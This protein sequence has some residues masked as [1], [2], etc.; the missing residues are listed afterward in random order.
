[1]S[2]RSLQY[3]I[4]RWLGHPDTRVVVLT[5]AALVGLAV[6]T[7]GLLVGILGP[8]LAIAFTG[9]LV[10]GLAILRDVRAGI[11]ATIAVC[12]LLPFATFPVD[13]G[14][15]PTFLNAVVG[16]VFLVYVLRL[17]TRRDSTF[18]TTSV[19]VPLAVFLL[20][21]LVAFAMGLTHS[22]PT[23]TVLRKFLEVLLALSMFY[24]MV[25]VVR[26]PQELSL[27]TRALILTGTGAAV[28]AILLY[29]MPIPWTVRVL[30]ALARLGYP[31][32]FGALRWIE[33]DP[34]NPMRAIGTAIDPNVLGGMMILAG[35]LTGPQLAS[36]RPLF[37][38]RWVFL[39]YVAQ[40]VALYLT[41][42]RGS[43]IGLFAALVVLAVLK[44]RRLLAF[45]GLGG[46]ILL[47]LPWSQAYVQHFIAGLQGQDR[48]TQ[49]RFGEY[50]DALRLISRYPWVGVGFTGSPDIDLYVGV[51]SVYLL[52][53]EQTGL[54]GLALYLITLAVFFRTLWRT[55]RQGMPDS[56]LES[57]LL[58]YGGAI[59]GVLVG[60]VFDHYLFNLVYPHMGTLFWMY[61]GLGVATSRL[62]AA[63]QSE[64]TEVPWNSTS[65]M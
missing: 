26:T 2:A 42:S 14:V 47:A 6:L 21:T 36:R 58:G 13:V 32:G 17:V 43:M 40:L 64:S 31:G 41:F 35:G 29:V 39:F 4:E 44:Y 7:I 53:A 55:W 49:M 48:A 38:R 59:V 28:I 20:W 8:L 25:N 1:M 54:I 37:R 9:G 30:N 15:T 11:L 19:G 3:T 16:A 10:V 27:F 52:I 57:V 61:V 5:R 33:D 45:I 60:G 12:F 56:L 22:R 63:R 34:A 24:V 23:P 50:K 18:V 62:I 46:G 51:S 65:R